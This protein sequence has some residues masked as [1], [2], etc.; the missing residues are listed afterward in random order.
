MT[1]AA[2]V[3]LPNFGAATPTVTGSGGGAGS[4]PVISWT[5]GDSNDPLVIG[6]AVL[7][8]SNAITIQKT[9]GM[10]LANP[11]NAAVFNPQTIGMNLANTANAVAYGQQTIGMRL[12][13]P[14]NAATYEPQTIGMR[15]A[16]PANAMVFNAQTTGMH[17]SGTALGAPA[18]QTVSATET[19]TNAT[20]I[21]ITK[22]SGTVDGDLLV[23]MVGFSVLVDQAVDVPAGWTQIIQQ[24]S[25]GLGTLSRIAAFYKF[26]SGEGATYTFTKASGAVAW[27]GTILRIAGVHATTPI[28]V[29]AGAGG[30]AA[31]PVAPTITTTST[32]CMKIAC[33]AQANAAA[34]SY[35]PPASYDEQSDGTATNLGVVQTTGEVATRVQAATGASGT[36]TM[37][38]TQ[39]LATN[40]AALHIAVAPGTLVLAP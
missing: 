22:P 27:I 31:D 15:L 33:C 14:A 39:L 7:N 13:N 25:G 37:D 8:P 3:A 16:N 20:S 21:V 38:S 18:I 6:M 11:A 26:A 35:T 28:N 5:P 4:N 34:A 10:R 2:G 19:T 9:I 29:S 1:F 17:L 32:N 40:Y 30:S 24:A 36:A 12:A 23:A